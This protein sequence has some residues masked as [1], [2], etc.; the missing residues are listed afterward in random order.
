MPDRVLVTGGSGFVA[1]WCI[2]RLLQ[3]GYAVNTTVRS[4]AKAPAVRDALAKLAPGAA[5]P[6]RLRFFE[7]DLM[8]DA[9]WAQAAAGCRYVLHVASPLSGPDTQDDSAF[10]TPARDGALRV[11][12]AAVAVGVERVVL[13]SSMAA[14]AYGHPK[15]RYRDGPPFSEIDWTDPT[16]HDANAYVRSKAIAERAAWDFIA[17]H[18]GQTQLAVV[19]PAGIFGPAMGP[20]FSGSL[21]I[22]VRLLK[23]T[24]PGLPPIGFSVVD[25]RDLADLH[26]L[27]MTKPEAAGHRF[28]AGGRF[29]WFADIARI[30]RDRLPPE[31]SAKV[32]TRRIPGWLLRIIA[33]RDPQVRALIH[34]LNLKRKMSQDAALALGWT[35]RSEED[36][37]VDTAL[38]LKA[39]GAI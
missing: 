16:Q 34:Q 37:L 6:E 30:L 1:G 27:V 8:S 28:P 10:V 23:G 22:I 17:A 32:P 9:G 12:K 33:L 15:A 20:D 25:V 36:C 29:L 3:A 35:P 39:V 38:S 5:D 14:I 26:L 2:E 24:M 7:A 4:L 31:L 13:T 19:N 18:G 11:L 21:Q